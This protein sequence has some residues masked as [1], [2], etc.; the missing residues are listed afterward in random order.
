MANAETSNREKKLR[1]LCRQ[2][3]SEKDVDQLLQIFLALHRVA[4]GD[5]PPASFGKR[6]DGVVGPWSH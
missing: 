1:D 2:A 6:L 5:M 4:E 3:V